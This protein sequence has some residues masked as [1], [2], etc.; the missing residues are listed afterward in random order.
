V[1]SLFDRYARKSLSAFLCAAAIFVAGCHSNNYTSGFGIAWVTLSGTPGDFTSYTVNV[2]SVTL[3]GKANGAYTPL[4]TVETVDFTKLNNISELWAAASVPNDTW[5][6]ASI[7]LDYTNANI[8]VMVNGVPTQATV[9]DTTGQPVTTQTINVTLDPANPLVIQP[10]YGSSSAV[11]LALDFDLAASNVVNLAT[12]PKPTVTVRPFMTAAT[13][14]PDTKPVRVRGPL[15]NSS[16]GVGSYTVFVR[17]FFDEV[18]SLGSLSIFNDANT[19]YTINGTTYVGAAG[20]TALSQT[21]AG[22]TITAAYTTYV[23]SGTLNAAVTA[24]KFNSNYVIAGST[25]EDFYTFGLEGDVI[26]RSGNTLTVRGATL[27]YSNG[28]TTS[29]GSY[30]S[31]IDT[32]DAVVLLGPGTV[33]TADGNATLTGLNYNSV[34]VG[35]HIIARGL[36]SL[37]AS[38]VTT[39]DATGTVTSKGSVRLVST[40]LWGSLVSSASGSLLLNLQTIENWPVSNYNFTGNGAAAVTPASYAVATGSLAIPAGVVAGDPVWIDGITTPFGSAPPDFNAFTIN[41]EVSVPAR[42]QVDWTSAGTTA[43]F[44]TLA[45]T[46][47]TIDL[48][49]ASAAVIRIGSESI[50]LKAAGSVS[51]LIVPQPPPAATAGL[52]PVFLPSFAIGNLT[53]TAGTTAITVYNT[54]STFVT[55]LP[56]AIA[57]ASPALHFVATGVYNRGSNTFTA[58]RIDVVN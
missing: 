21:S 39:L 24:G 40:Q 31:Y 11:R 9:V 3:T 4:A 57:A 6:A 32:P 58:S 12:S 19:V 48:N 30:T 8:S 1:H 29:Y 33:V 50:D 37:P 5:T 56:T 36:Y 52:P 38:G 10:T 20:L 22:T 28:G 2:D 25:L 42:L 27:Q 55:Q 16:V 45:D 18:S 7:V 17:P 15:I 41:A 14:A 54:F 35:Q 47:L 13:S 46:G 44:A 49:T 23:P 34:S 51:P 43:P 53:A 26:A